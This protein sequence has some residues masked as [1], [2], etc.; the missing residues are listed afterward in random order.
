[1]WVKICGTTNTEDARAAAGA[2][3]DALG[4]VFAPSSRRISP[5]E[6]KKIIAELPKELEKIGVFVNQTAG[7]ILDTVETAGLTGV[8]LHGDEDREFVRQLSKRAKGTRIYKVLPA[9]GLLGAAGA[10]MADEFAGAVRALV[11]DS[12]SR[13][14]RGGTGKRFQWDEAAPLVRLMSKRFKVVVA[15]GLTPE[16]VGEAIAGLQPWG[17]DVV[18][19]V[20]SEPGKKDAAKVR[21]FVEAAKSARP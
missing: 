10:A 7:I 5:K 11:L 15:G 4:F 18:S 20:E 1:M 16:N 9:A 19:G 3:A 8:Q 13:E 6:A 14:Q 17:V 12:G 2:G 21:A